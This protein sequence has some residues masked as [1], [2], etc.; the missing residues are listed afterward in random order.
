[1]NPSP[2]ATIRLRSRTARKL[3]KIGAGAIHRRKD[4]GT[5]HTA[6]GQVAKRLKCAIRKP[7]EGVRVVREPHRPHLQGKRHTVSSH[8]QGRLSSK[9]ASRVPRKIGESRATRHYISTQCVR[10]AHRALTKNLAF[11]VVGKLRPNERMSTCALRERGC[12]S[13]TR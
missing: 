4:G 8:S 9:T 1:M 3:K 5:V 11:K 13:I 2:A 10:R 7:R 12:G 6:R